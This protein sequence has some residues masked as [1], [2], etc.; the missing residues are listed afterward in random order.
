MG[1]SFIWQTEKVMRAKPDSQF[2]ET[3]KKGFEKKSDDPEKVWG[4]E[5]WR[6]L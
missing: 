4:K 6:H 3:C 2:F 1:I 5:Y